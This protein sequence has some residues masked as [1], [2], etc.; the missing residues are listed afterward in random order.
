MPE[1]SKDRLLPEQAI[2]S[3]FASGQ[4][5]E[6]PN[7]FPFGKDFGNGD[8]DARVLQ[9]DNQFDVYREQ[10]MRARAREYG[11]YVC[12]LVSRNDV[13]TKTINNF[14]TRVACS[15]Y[16]EYFRKQPSENGWS[17]YCALSNETLWFDQEG[18]FS[19]ADINLAEPATGY[20]SG[21]DALACQIQEDICVINVKDTSDQLIAAHLCFPNRWSA[22]QKIGK[23]FSEIHRP[24]AR[25]AESN[26]N[27]SKLVK[28]LM[29]GKPYIRFAWGLSNDP[30]LD[31]HPDTTE[32]F[33]FNGDEDSLYLRV[34]RQVLVG[35]PKNDL[36]FFFIRTYYQDCRQVCQDAGVTAGL[37]KT[38]MS[39]N[40]DLLGYKGLSES[41]N[42]I[43][44]WLQ[45]IR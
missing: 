19:G 31:H 13:D 28:A 33:H 22:E 26:P 39:I 32:N 30:L 38:L 11:K 3:P 42:R 2:Y 16:P 36:L 37:V 25:F 4:Y 17:L 45:A 14:L 35:L 15:E 1:K 8:R 10:K 18:A 40:S 9:L 21:L 44:D 27:T 34:E 29:G 43:V 6:K 20:R 7:L 12:E 23:S 5:N 41:R 24:V